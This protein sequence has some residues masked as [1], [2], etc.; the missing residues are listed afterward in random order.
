MGSKSLG[1]LTLDLV[2]KIG[3]FTGPMDKV[4]RRVKSSGKNIEKY[5]TAAAASMKKVVA[6]AAT[7]A[8]AAGIGAL[9]KN[10]LEATS[11]ISKMAQMAGVSTT[12]F[13]ELNYAASQYKVSVDA[14][15]D[16]LKELNLR[17][18]EY[19]YTGAGPGE[20]A[21]KRL[22]YTQD[23]LK[24]KLKD[25]PALF[26]EII[27]RMQGMDQASKMRLADEIFGG[28]G[29]EQFVAVI[30]GGSEA[31]HDF[32]VEA[33]KLGIVMDDA[34]LQKSIDAEREISKL[35]TI[36]R[37]QFNNVLAGLSPSIIATSEAMGD[38][39]EKNHEFIAQDFAGAVQG[40]GSAIGNFVPIAKEVFDTALKG[41]NTLPTVIKEVGIVGAVFG[42]TKG[43]LAILATIESVGYAK[44]KLDDFIA[45]F[46]G[47]A[48]LS[49]GIEEIKEKIK[50]VT[51]ALEE[52]EG[53]SRGKKNRMGG[54]VYWQNQIKL[55]NDYKAQLKTLEASEASGLTDS[56]LLRDRG[57]QSPSK[58]WG[59]LNAAESTDN[60]AK[61]T[62]DE[63]SAAYQ[64]MYSRI[65]ASSQAVYDAMV[66]QYQAD[67][68]EFIALTGDKETAYADY[69]ARL[70]ALNSEF[71]MTGPAEEI[72]AQQEAIAA[73]RQAVKDAIKAL[74]D[75]YDIIGKNEDQIALYRL[76]MQGATDDQLAYAESMLD[77]LDKAERYQAALEEG[78]Q[79]KESLRTPTEEYSDAVEHLK[80]LWSAGALEAETY[81]RA[82]EKIK[83]ELEDEVGGDYWS[84][85]LSS[86][87]SNMQN[88]D[89]LVGSSIN[90]WASQFGS[91]F[92][93][94]IMDSDNLGD[95]IET[96]ASGMA[97]S[98]VSAI[99]QMA[100]QWLVYQATKLLVDKTTQS[101]AAV[102]M[103]ANA[104]AS[105]LQAGI[106]AYASAA[107]IPITGWALAPGAMAAALA[108]TEPMAAAVAA[109]AT[110]AT[111]GIAHEGIDRVPK[112]GTWLLEEGERVITENTSA[113]L[114]KTLAAIQRTQASG[115]SGGS[116]NP[117]NVNVYEAAGTT[118][119][120][121][122]SADG[123]SI[124]VIIERVEKKMAGRMGRGT[125]LAGFLD[126][127]YGRKY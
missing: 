74:E 104:E 50:D 78:K 90:S 41:W 88:M 35:S 14:L 116:E 56:W 80:E 69:T 33:Q 25:L 102:A 6:A 110:S 17:A 21:F 113:R 42:G 85:L 5:G 122:Q 4:D 11:E 83:E 40:A 92:A 20:E 65:G 2:A 66:A 67:R 38:W 58:S 55:L 79:L 77:A 95:A 117:M 120:V 100:A 31:L 86:M 59:D 29:G 34:M 52:Y 105:A 121:N 89:Q 49:L 82:L 64:A 37:G 106:N 12:T 62:A 3:G 30:N 43:R 98:M 71:D 19:V 81:Q 111:V 112:S 22:G 125:G 10:S 94:A 73:Q 118:A 47:T 46:S 99:G 39:I 72:Y 57:G 107:A 126:R 27:D 103:T 76:E 36:L 101:G 32:Q 70:E 51:A 18:E 45:G 44:K 23:E 97:N 96:L 7:L 114:D 15:T 13:Q 24:E 61:K 28:Q 87:E 109:L 119:T 124:N 108:V 53:A 16:G 9:V 123:Q 115:A 54:V 93:S 68:D 84:E 1:T 8:G 91:F 75:Q 48:D 63:I 127:R 60:A 26:S